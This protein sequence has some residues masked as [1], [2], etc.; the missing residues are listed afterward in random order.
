MD[1][2]G[3]L[4]KFD[5]LVEATVVEANDLRFLER[6]CTVSDGVASL[7]TPK[8]PT[9]TT[10]VVPCSP[11]ANFRHVRII[12]YRCDTVGVQAFV[13]NCS[14]VVNTSRCRPNNLSCVGVGSSP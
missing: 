9:C 14:C 13:T 5:C 8:G 12:Q 10:T 4:R 6:N 2:V 3:R 11:E 7:I 1:I